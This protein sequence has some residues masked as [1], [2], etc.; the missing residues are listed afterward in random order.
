MNENSV[1]V[2]RL[3][4]PTGNQEKMCSDYL[5]ALKYAVD[6]YVIENIFSVRN[7]QAVQDIFSSLEHSD[8]NTEFTL[9]CIIATFNAENVFG[10][11][12]ALFQQPLIANYDIVPDRRSIVFDLYKKAYA[13]TQMFLSCL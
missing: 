6:K 9:N 2:V 3:E 13:Q 12:V 10:L 8:T 5:S 11:T 1:Y 7:A 4:T